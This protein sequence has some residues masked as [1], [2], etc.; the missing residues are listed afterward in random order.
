MD[1]IAADDEICG[2]GGAIF[3]MYPRSIAIFLQH[4]AG[5]LEL[6]RNALP[7]STFRQIFFVCNL[8]APLSST[9]F[10]RTSKNSALC[11]GNC[12]TRCWSLEGDGTVTISAPSS[13]QRKEIQTPLRS[14]P[15]P[16][17]ASPKPIRCRSLA[18]LTPMPTPAPISE[19]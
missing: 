14:P 18:A 3:E 13:Y 19:Y 7:T 16:F 12:R 6:K 10:S 2:Y 1:T 5:K 17:I 9:A 8:A 11:T 4:S 15:I